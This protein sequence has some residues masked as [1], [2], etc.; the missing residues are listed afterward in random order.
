MDTVENKYD[1]QLGKPAPGVWGKDLDG[2]DKARQAMPDPELYDLGWDVTG[3]LRD[4]ANDDQV[5]LGGDVDG[6]SSLK[7]DDYPSNLAPGT[8][9]H[10]ANNPGANG[11]QDLNFGSV[12]PYKYPEF[13]SWPGPEPTAFKGALR[14]VED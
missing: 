2:A 5:L 10:I 11:R 13:G 4:A 1:V 7:D 12:A 3:V 8:T 9:A 14:R 6:E